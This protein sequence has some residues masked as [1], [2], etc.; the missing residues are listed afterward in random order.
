MTTPSEITF[1]SLAIALVQSSLVLGEA[2]GLVGKFMIDG[3][4]GSQWVETAAGHGQRAITYHDQGQA[5]FALEAFTDSVRCLTREV[6]L[7]CELAIVSNQDDAHPITF[8]DLA[9]GIREASILL[10]QGTGRKSRF[11]S[12]G[13]YGN[14][15]THSAAWYAQEA[16]F[17]HCAHAQAKAD[18][19]MRS[20]AKVLGEEANMVRQLAGSIAG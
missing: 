12:M 20:A 9:Q 18:E 7:V 4:I 15:W 1:R 16:I 2:R 17:Q 11:R 6:Q 3:R 13:N 14:L 10:V 5:Y 8:L 19:L